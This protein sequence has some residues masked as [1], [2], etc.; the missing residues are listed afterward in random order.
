MRL[1]GAL[2]LARSNTQ[3]L[4]GLLEAIARLVM[5]CERDQV[6]QLPFSMCSV[7]GG[8]HSQAVCRSLHGAGHAAAA[9]LR[10]A[11]LAG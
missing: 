2:Q 7:A 10:T 3:A 1:R 11:E 5:R 8:T 9:L 4:Y 6:P